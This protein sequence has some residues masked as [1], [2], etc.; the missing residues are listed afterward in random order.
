MHSRWNPEAAVAFDEA[1]VLSLYERNGL[2]LAA[3]PARGTWW[4]GRA[5]S[6]YADYQDRLVA[7]RAAS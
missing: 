3:A 4:S 5:P 2:A 1:Y 6:G 7:V